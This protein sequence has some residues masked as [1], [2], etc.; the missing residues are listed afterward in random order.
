MA[1]AQQTIPPER[2]YDLQKLANKSTF[3]AIVLGFFLSPLAYVY[4][5]R[6]LLALVNLLTLNWFLTGFIVVPLHTRKII[7][8]ARAELRAVGAW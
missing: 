5:G 7:K 8:S 3:T 2:R 1:Q 6:P 4:V